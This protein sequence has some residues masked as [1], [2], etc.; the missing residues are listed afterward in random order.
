MA[1]EAVFYKIK[2]VTVNYNGKRDLVWVMQ[3][4]TAV[5]IWQEIGMQKLLKI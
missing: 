5:E 2:E 3:G 4:K 1:G